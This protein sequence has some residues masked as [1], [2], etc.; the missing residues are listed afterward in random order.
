MLLARALWP[1]LK[2]PELKAENDNRKPENDGETPPPSSSPPSSP[3]PLGDPDIAEMNEQFALVILRNGHAFLKLDEVD[4][5]GRPVLTLWNKDTFTEWLAD[6]FVVRNGRRLKL[7]TYWRTNPQRRKFKGIVF[8]PAHDREGYY[9]LFRGFPVK[10]ADQD[11]QGDYPTLREHLLLNVCGGNEMFY[12]W[13]F[14]WFAH[15]VQKPDE[16]VGT[17]VV[18]RG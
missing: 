1:E 14:G 8:A 6:R 12:E 18:L 13:V 10:P 2:W 5:K 3:L 7:S 9:N 4:E 17:S 15:I 16:K 11:A